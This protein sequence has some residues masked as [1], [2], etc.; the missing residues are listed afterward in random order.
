MLTLLYLQVTHD[1]LVEVAAAASLKS[2]SVNSEVPWIEAF[3]LTP[4]SRPSRVV[5]VVCGKHDC[6]LIIFLFLNKCG[7]LRQL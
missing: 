4:N 7:F 3:G 5:V 2:S 1:D 6:L